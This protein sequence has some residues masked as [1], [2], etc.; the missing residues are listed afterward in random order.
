MG[1][2]IYLLER[3]GK[4]KVELS[5]SVPV[6]NMEKAEKE[7]HEKFGDSRI[8]DITRKRMPV[9][10]QGHY[11]IGLSKDVQKRVEEINKSKLKN[12][13]TEYF[14][15]NWLEVLFIIIQMIWIS[16]RPY[17]LTITVLAFGLYVYLNL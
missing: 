14:A 11:K 6:M 1:G 4:N 17:F 16:I 12:G 10:F 8:K 3:V 9:L 13:K 2:Y 7:L 15:A 5:F